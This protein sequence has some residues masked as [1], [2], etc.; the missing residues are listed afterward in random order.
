MVLPPSPPMAKRVSLTDPSSTVD[1]TI[2]W[3][4]PVDSWEEQAE[5]Q[6]KDTFKTVNN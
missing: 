5:G 6:T 4:E 1:A 2:G 3:V